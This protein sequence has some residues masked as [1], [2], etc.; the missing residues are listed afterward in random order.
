M[1]TTSRTVPDSRACGPRV[2]GGGGDAVVV[3]RGVAAWVL[4][5][6]LHRNVIAGRH[7][8]TGMSAHSSAWMSFLLPRRLPP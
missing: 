5:A 8:N 6:R 4:D 3:D 2:T 7:G 1:R